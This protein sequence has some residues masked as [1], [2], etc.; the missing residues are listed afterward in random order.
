MR[1]RKKVKLS[2]IKFLVFLILIGGIIWTWET[3]KLKTKVTPP[4]KPVSNEPHPK[5]TTI[6]FIAGGDALVHSA[7]RASGLQTD[8]TYNFDAQ[9]D[10]IRDILV[11]YD[12]KF[13]NQESMI[14]G[15]TNYL[16][17]KTGLYFNTPTA[18]G[19]A[20]LKAGFNLVSLANNHSMDTGV[21]GVL[22]SVAYWKK[23]PNI[24]F[25][26]LADSV[27]MRNDY[28]HLI[29]TIN[30]IT[31]GFLAYTTHTN[32][33]PI[34]K[35]KP[36]LVKV[37]HEAEVAQDIEKLRPQVDVLIVSMHWGNEYISEPNQQEKEIAQFLANQKVDIIIGNHAHCIQPI[38]KI[39]K[40][41]VFYS[42][43]NLMSNQGLLTVTN[44]SR[45]G[46]KVT[47]GALGFLTITKTVYP[48]NTTEIV[49]DNV[50]AELT[51]TYSS[52]PGRNEDPNRKYKIIPFSKIKPEDFT[53]LT[54]KYRGNPPKLNDLYSD[55]KNILQKYNSTIK[56][57]PLPNN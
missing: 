5:V 51:Y 18:Y 20:A 17:K 33:N 14:N 56:V 4:S 48:D 37:Y 15:T 55:Y 42:L 27:E 30:N 22:G 6:K 24:I 11:Q 39:G 12:L 35:D 29:G 8:G 34:P 23:Q 40:T 46:Q 32:G 38:D 21:Q 54:A 50:G 3:Q 2:L 57:V 47:I 1:L 16:E 44:P 41:I 52:T 10:L 9:F 7:V 13:Y 43:G 26:G 28:S 45:Y 36:Y 53:I 31:Y 19:D 25:D 49:I